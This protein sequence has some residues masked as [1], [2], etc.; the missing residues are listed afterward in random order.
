MSR[1]PKEYSWYLTSGGAHE[2]IL[3]TDA[4]APANLLK[5]VSCNCSGNCTTKRCSCKKNN[6]K[7]ISACGTSMAT[8]ARTLMLKLRTP[9]TTEP[10]VEAFFKTLYYIEKKV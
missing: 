10:H 2:P 5:F 1:D 6:V 8:S 9:L 3:I 4:I 7:C